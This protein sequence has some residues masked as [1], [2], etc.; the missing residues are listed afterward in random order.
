MKP[1]PQS[2]KP[3]SG[4]GKPEFAVLFSVSAV[5]RYFLENKNAECAKTNEKKAKRWRVQGASSP[6]TKGTIFGT[7]IKNEDVLVFERVQRDGSPEPPE[8]LKQKMFAAPKP[9]YAANTAGQVWTRSEII[10]FANFCCIQKRS[11]ERERE[12]TIARE[13]RIAVQENEGADG[14]RF[15]TRASLPCNGFIFLSKINVMFLLFAVIQRRI[16]RTGSVQRETTTE[17]R[18]GEAWRLSFSDEVFSIFQFEY[19]FSV[20]ANLFEWSAKQPS[21][22]KGLPQTTGTVY[23]RASSLNFRFRDQSWWENCKIR[24]IQNPEFGWC[25]CRLSGVQS[26]PTLHRPSAYSLKPP[27]LPKSAESETDWEEANRSQTLDLSFSSKKSMSKVRTGS[28]PPRSAARNDL[29][30]QLGTSVFASQ[31]GGCV[32]FDF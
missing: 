10:L 5:F 19:K 25:I 31:G 30:V 1:P 9:K 22:E 27:S 32:D 24:S 11:A 2:S 18:S 16:G 6:Q 14:E 4:A 8:V 28:V 7:I 21:G 17:R 20:K 15:V 13:E 12:Q 26:P 23:S 3:A 29:R